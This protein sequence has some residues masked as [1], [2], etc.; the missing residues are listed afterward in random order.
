MRA[1]VALV[2]A[3]AERR[4]QRSRL[5]CVRSSLRR[6]LR[7]ERCAAGREEGGARQAPCRERRPQ[8]HPLQRASRRRRRRDPPARLPPRPRGYRL[9]EGRGSL[10]IRAG[11]DVA[12]GQ[13]RA[14]M[15][16]RRRGLHAV[17]GREER[18]RA[19]S[20]WASTSAA[21]S[22]RPAM[23]GPDSAR[24]RRQGALPEARSAAHERAGLQGRD[25]PTPRRSGGWSPAWSRRSSIAAGPA[26]ARIWHAVLQG[27]RRGR[28]A[29][30]GGTARR[31]RRC[32]SGRQPLRR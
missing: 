29:E 17:H 11:Q 21:S 23:S 1:S 32:R 20:C 12:Q 28:R 13:V 14:R 27:S 30:R 9:E 22:S 31:R 4:R 7:S 5:L 19:R 6:R 10:P 15:A 25:W 8:P 24:T 18:D 2:E 26:P 16:V 3:L